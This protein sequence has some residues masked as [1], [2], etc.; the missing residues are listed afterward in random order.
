MDS[1]NSGVLQGGGD[2]E[3]GIR[4]KPGGHMMEVDVFGRVWSRGVSRSLDVVP[5]VVEPTCC[6]VL[7]GR[8][9]FGLSCFGRVQDLST[10]KIYQYSL[11]YILVVYILYPNINLTNLG[12]IILIKLSKIISKN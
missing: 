3:R 8:G 5:R 6:S 12:I 4:R 10:V 7:L 9:N 11:N 2:R 1:L